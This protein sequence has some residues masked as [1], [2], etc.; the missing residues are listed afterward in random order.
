M[1]SRHTTAGF[2]RGFCPRRGLRELSPLSVLKCWD[3]NRLR[4]KYPQIWPNIFRE[5]L[6]KSSK[7]L[8]KFSKY[9]QIFL[10]ISKFP[11]NSDGAYLFPSPNAA[12]GCL[13]TVLIFFSAQSV[14]LT[15]ELKTCSETLHVMTW[16]V[17]F[18]NKN[19]QL[20]LHL[21]PSLVIVLS[22][23]LIFGQIWASLFL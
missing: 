8:Q 10:N 22:L 21:K 3:L 14:F 4:Y 19:L 12:N 16:C 11:E 9:L 23:F 15:A 18:F 6:D 13:G 1:I 20:H 5:I 17:V 7:Y 2:T